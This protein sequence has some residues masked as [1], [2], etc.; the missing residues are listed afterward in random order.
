MTKEELQNIINKCQNE[1]MFKNEHD[2]A[3]RLKE[4][5]ENDKIS[6]EQLFMFAYLESINDSSEL[7]FKVLSEVLTLD[8]KS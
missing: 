7:L 5:S 2:I 6:N 8:D 4:Y 3:N 1:M